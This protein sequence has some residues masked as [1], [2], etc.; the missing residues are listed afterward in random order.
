MTFSTPITM[1]HCASRTMGHCVSEG[2]LTGA[3]SRSRASARDAELV[4][5]SP[6]TADVVVLA[7]GL[8]IPRIAMHRCSASTTTIDS[9]RLELAHQRVRDLAGQPFL[10]LRPLRVEVDEPCELGQ[11]RHPPGGPGDVADVGDTVE[12]DQVVLARRVHRDVA[13]Q[14]EFLVPFVEGGV[15]HL[16]GICEQSA[17]HLAVGARDPRR[18]V[19]QPLTLGVLADGDQQFPYGRLGPGLIEG[20]TRR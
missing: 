8:R 13:H 18:G 9:A 17:E 15:E 16:V 5:N 12:G 11:A 19:A 14:D 3:E 4:W 1:G 10:H 20:S 7:P 6:R 2:M